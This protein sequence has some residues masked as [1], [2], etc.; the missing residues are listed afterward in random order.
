MTPTHRHEECE[1]QE[2]LNVPEPGVAPMKTLLLGICITVTAAAI[3][4]TGV[5]AIDSRVEISSL[6]TQRLAD[7]EY[8]DKQFQ[9]LCERDQRLEIILKEIRDDQ[10][11]RKERGEKY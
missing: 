6:K 5:A 9:I 2:V 4:G 8:L 1:E 7:R 11:V 3:I 10:K